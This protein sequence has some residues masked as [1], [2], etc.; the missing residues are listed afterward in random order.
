MWADP[1]QVPSC[2]PLLQQDQRKKDMAKVIGVNV[3]TVYQELQRNKTKRGG[4]GW[5]LGKLKAMTMD[6][7]SEFA[8]LYVK[9]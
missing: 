5:P 4:Y 9:I 6:N 2:V 7:G 8:A 3:S 1:K